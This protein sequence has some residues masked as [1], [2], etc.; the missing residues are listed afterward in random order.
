MDKCCLSCGSVVPPRRGGRKFCGER[1]RKDH[2]RRNPPPS[3]IEAR[4]RLIKPAPPRIAFKCCSCGLDVQIKRKSGR[5]PVGPECLACRTKKRRPEYQRAWRKNNA[6]KEKAY[7]KRAGERRA[8][9]RASD[10]ALRLHHSVSSQIRNSL[11]G[12]KQGRKWETI[13]GYTLLDL[14]AH[15][16]RQFCGNMTWENYGKRW[17]IDHIVPRRYFTFTSPNDDGFKACWSLANLR[18]LDA[19]DNL[20]KGGRRTMLL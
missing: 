5:R 6:T 19:V 8:K 3:V 2:Y 20:R 9:K 13:V 1:C 10:P 4:M 11:A 17:H 16:E 12:A 14:Q 7:Q 15:I 18:P